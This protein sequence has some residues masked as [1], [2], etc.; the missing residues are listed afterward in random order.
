MPKREF[1]LI[2]GQC[3]KQHHAKLIPVHM[4]SIF[5]VPSRHIPIEMPCGHVSDKTYDAEHEIIRFN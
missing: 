5:N 2:C 3:G 4:P 1:N